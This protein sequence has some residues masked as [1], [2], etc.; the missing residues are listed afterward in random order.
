MA[1]YPWFRNYDAGVPRTL[2]PYP[3]KTL[4]DVVAET[5]G[6]RPGHTMMWFKGNVITYARFQT[7]VE[8]VARALAGLGVKRGDRVALLMPNIPQIIICQFAVWK[9]GGVAVPVNPLYSESELVHALKDCGAEMAVVMTPFYGQLKNIQPKTRVKTVIATG[10]KEYLTPFKR[11][12]FGLLMEK[13]QG[14]YVELQAGDLWLQD[15]IRQYAGS[16]SPDFKLGFD[17]TGLILFSGGTTGVPKG[18]MLSHGC[19]LM[20]GMQTRAWFGKLLVDWED[21]TILLMPLFHIY[22]NIILV[23]TLLN[24]RVPIVLV[25]NPRDVP[26]LLATIRTTKPKFFPGIATLFIGLMNH[27]D[28]KSGKIDFRSMKM[29]VAA[30]APLL[31]ETKKSWEA[32]TGGKLVEAY[33]LTESGIIAMGPILGKWK[34]GAVGLPTPDVQVKIVDIETGKKEMTVGETGE[35]IVRAPHLMQ[36]YWNNPEATAEMLR[37][38]WLYTG[39]VGHLDSDGYLFIT[40]RKKELIKPSGHQVF[41][42]E[43]EEA[44]AKHPAVL[45]VGVAGVKDAAQGEAVKAWVVL[46]PDQPCTAEELQAFCKER[47]TAYKVPKH[48]EFRDSLPK[49]LIGKV[50]RRVLQEEELKK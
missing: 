49:S 4:L 27:P 12:M 50:L 3:D 5:A 47:L 25:P 22:G 8:D 35:I 15:I 30:A 9:A 6:Q 37:D 13:K 21:V 23:S 38:G 28:V 19:I 39:D 32:L 17:E 40:S 31:P 7:Y 41:P 29:C 18:V 34:E 43:V 33:G 1:D 16:P 11:L 14:H 48:I 44:I 45:E 36:G 26:D 42:V 46:Q 24:A 2:A 10:V 20:N